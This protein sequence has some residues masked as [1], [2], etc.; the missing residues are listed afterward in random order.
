MKGYETFSY[1]PKPDTSDIS[2]VGLDI[3]GLVSDKSDKFK[4]SEILQK[5]DLRW[6]YPMDPENGLGENA[7][8]IQ[9]SEI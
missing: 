5:I 9:L 6:I 3:S 2:D 8:N 4:L 7:R 1:R